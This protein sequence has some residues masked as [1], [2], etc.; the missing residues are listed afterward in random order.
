MIC[1]RMTTSLYRELRVEGADCD[2]PPL[3]TGTVR[4][5]PTLSPRQPNV[6]LQ[7]AERT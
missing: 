2:P 5:V 6:Q 7:V 4:I 1:D 3:V